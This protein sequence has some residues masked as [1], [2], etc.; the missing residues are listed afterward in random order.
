MKK[1]IILKAVVV[2][3]LLAWT[4]VQVQAFQIVTR[5]MILEERVLESDLIPTVDNFII[6]FDT[7]ATTNDRVPGKD[8]PIITAAKNMLKARNAWLPDLGY[9][10]GLYVYT[11]NTT[12]LGTFKEIYGVKPYDRDAFAAAIDQLPEKGQ[13]PT[14][15]QTAL[16]QV[17]KILSGLTGKTAVIM[18]TDGTFT[19]NRNI[20]PPLQVAKEIARA[21]DVCFYLISS[22]DEKKEKALLD[23]VSSINCCSRVVPL[24]VFLDNPHYI[25]GAL[26]TTRTRSYTRLKPITKVVG[27]VAEDIHFALN[28]S[29]L[30]SDYTA[31]L[32]TIGTY[33]QNNRDAYMVVSGY[34]D[35]RGEEEYNLWLSQRRAENVK[36][37]IVDG[38]GIDA[39]RIVDLWFGHLNPVSENDTEAG[40]QLN[41]RVEI[42][43]GGI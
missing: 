41:R 6:L 12:L 2:G 27:I 42:A 18:F 19:I 26:Y 11:D 35:N 29:I 16:H 1:T 17:R 9:N 39:N 40:R 23:A 13:G 37:Y 22:A 21:H 30:K 15:L 24:S 3:L 31:R 25:G 28:S 14:M 43:I 36:K 8:M 38:F 34:T 20:K 32:D 10:A 4:A 33:L 5:E 7:S